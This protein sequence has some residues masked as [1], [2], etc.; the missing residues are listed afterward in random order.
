MTE[1]WSTDWTPVEKKPVEEKAL[2]PD[3][4]VQTEKKLPS[5]DEKVAPV[6][7]EKDEQVAISPDAAVKTEKKPEQPKKAPQVTCLSCGAAHDKDV[8]MCPACL[9]IGSV[10]Q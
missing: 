3:Q 2:S 4:A 10:D 7:V 6:K 5:K 1:K 8:E 9:T